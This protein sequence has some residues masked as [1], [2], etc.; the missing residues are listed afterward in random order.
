MDVG[1]VVAQMKHDLQAIEVG[2]A[3][4]KRRAFIFLRDVH[5]PCLAKLLNLE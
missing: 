5:L 1:D 4:E 2:A 3:D